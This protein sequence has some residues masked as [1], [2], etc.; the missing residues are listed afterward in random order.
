MLVITLAGAGTLPL[1]Q[2]I[3]VIYGT[4]LGA[5]VLRLFLSVGMKGD[6]L[7]LVRM[8]DLFC[9]ASG[10]LMMGLFY[11]EKADVP[12]IGSLVRAVGSGPPIQLACVFLLSNLLPAIA[13]TPIL[14]AC[15]RL[16]KKWWPNDPTPSAGVPAF[17]TTQALADPASAL[18]LLPKELARLLT[19]VDVSPQARTSEDPES[20]ISPD[21]AKLGTAIETFCA[22]LAS[23]NSLD[24]DQALRLQRH[25]AWLHTIRHIGEAVGEFSDSLAA[26]TP[27]DAY[28]AEGLKSWLTKALDLAAKATATLDADE[29]ETFHAETKH[30]IPATESVRH[31][32]AQAIETSTSA[33]K[34]A[35]ASLGDQF[36]IAEWLIHRI[37]KLEWKATHPAP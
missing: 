20:H 1:E 24:A 6:A 11:L 37:S 33:S 23:E 36:D 14:P 35:L 8:E 4:N 29:V 12:L 15:A 31:T 18:D 19:S 16:L 34:L 30:D 27:E 25:R 32:F 2:A 9:V 21:F 28:L 22:R 17:L 10:I 7:R 26:L 13:L 3:P 5:I